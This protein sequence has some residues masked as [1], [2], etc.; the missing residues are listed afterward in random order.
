VAIFTGVGFY[1]FSVFL[2]QLGTGCFTTIG[3]V[4]VIV[5]INLME[6]I[7]IGSYYGT[8]MEFSVGGGG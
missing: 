2:W 5:G 6:V 7:G 3:G 8:G 1:E 4:Q